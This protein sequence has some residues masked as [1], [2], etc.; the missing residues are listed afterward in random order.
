M[1]LT[2][3]WNNYACQLWNPYTSES[4]SILEGI[5]K[6]ACIVCLGQRCLDYETMLHHLQLDIPM[7]LTRCRYLKITTMFN[8]HYF[9]TGVFMRHSILSTR[10]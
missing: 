10:H 5:Q 7:L 3:S 8:I 9:P 2:T 1:H 4:I 6:F